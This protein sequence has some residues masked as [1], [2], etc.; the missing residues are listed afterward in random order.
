M[1][2]EGENR[3]TEDGI[4]ERGKNENDLPRLCEYDVDLVEVIVLK[5]QDDDESE[6]EEEK[7]FRR[8]DIRIPMSCAS[9]RDAAELQRSRKRKPQEDKIHRSE[10]KFITGVF[11]SLMF[12]DPD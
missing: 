5:D 8:C 10:N 9:K 4:K 3:E 12:N 11:H 2:E 7:E 6:N 1:D